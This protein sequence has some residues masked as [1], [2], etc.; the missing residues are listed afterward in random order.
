MNTFSFVP[1]VFDGRHH[2]VM[3]Y[4]A[5]LAYHKKH[6]NKMPVDGIV[7]ALEHGYINQ[8][9][10]AHK[11]LKEHIQTL[12]DAIDSGLPYEV[13]TTLDRTAQFSRARLQLIN[14]Y[15]NR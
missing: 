15:F 3:P 11:S 7:F 5:I 4:E 9:N 2:G 12:Q 6:E 10:R 1:T 8:L 14:A 13:W